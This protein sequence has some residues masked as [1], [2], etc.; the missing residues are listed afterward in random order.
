MPPSVP[1]H[2]PDPSLTTASWR[3]REG[4]EGEKR[5]RERRRGRAEGGRGRVEGGRGKGKEE[6]RERRGGREKR[7]EKVGTAMY[8]SEVKKTLS[9]VYQPMQGGYCQL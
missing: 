3:G 2:I 4:G 5:R 8:H 1:L 9:H 6:G 7:G